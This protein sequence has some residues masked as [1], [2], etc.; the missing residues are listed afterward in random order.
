M[1]RTHL[2]ILPTPVF[3]VAIESAKLTTIARFRSVEQFTPTFFVISFK[4]W[5]QKFTF[6]QL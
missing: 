4:K 5:L 1:R 6:A 3:F 2:N